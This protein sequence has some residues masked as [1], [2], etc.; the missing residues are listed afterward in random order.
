MSTALRYCECGRD[1]E[2]YCRICSECRAVNAQIAKDIY[3]STKQGKESQDKYNKSEKGKLSRRKADKTWRTK[4]REANLKRLS[5]WKKNNKDHVKNY[6]RE[7]YKS[8]LNK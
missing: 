6:N 4:N 5:D 2:K 1:L 3:N 8:K 7:Y